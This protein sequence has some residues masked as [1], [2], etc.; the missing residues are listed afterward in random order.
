M[1]IKTV[2]SGTASVIALSPDP[3][4]ILWGFSMAET[5]GT[6]ATAEIV[7]R[8]GIT[9]AGDML[10]APVNFASD[11]FGYPTFFPMPI[12]VPNGIFLQRVS[13]ETTVVFY[14]D[15]Q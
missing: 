12:Q 5:A 8:H 6:A 13:G 4:L 10:A 14:Y 7:I 9:V 3:M 1:I 15:K 11:G 2:G